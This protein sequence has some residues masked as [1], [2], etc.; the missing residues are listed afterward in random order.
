MKIRTTVG[1]AAGIAVW[2]S[3]FL[4]STFLIVVAWPAS[5]RF[6]QSVFEAGDYS[7]FP[8]AML[9]LFLIMY[10]PIGLLAGRATVSITRDRR[11]AWI[12]AAPLLLFAA[13]QHL[14][15]LWNNLPNWYNVAV[16]AVIAPGIVLGGRSGRAGVR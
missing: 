15:V 8:V 4:A 6:R 10:I 2:W 5:E 3:L 11:H 12:V 14:F 1:V 7:V 9:L 16:V 13:Y